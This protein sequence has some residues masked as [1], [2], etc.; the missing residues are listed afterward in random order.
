MHIW[1]PTLSPS[2]DP[3]APQPSVKDFPPGTT[4]TRNLIALVDTYSTPFFSPRNCTTPGP[5]S[6]TPLIRW[7]NSSCIGSDDPFPR[8][9][10]TKWE[11]NALAPLALRRCERPSVDTK[12]VT[13]LATSG[14][15]ESK[16]G[17]RIHL[18]KLFELVEAA[19]SQD[20]HWM[21]RKSE[22]ALYCRECQHFPFY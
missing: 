20:N 12:L 8:M 15:K 2:G 22:S 17:L 9:P 21:P 16:Q 3:P 11:L 5:R 1:D 10:A 4:S 19:K 13:F 14:W 7:H 6:G 18:S